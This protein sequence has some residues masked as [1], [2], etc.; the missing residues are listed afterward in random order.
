MFGVVQHMFWTPD[1]RMGRRFQNGYQELEEV[2]SW[3]F[4]MTTHRELERSETLLLVMYPLSFMW[5]MMII[6]QQFQQM[7]HIW[8]YLM[9]TYGHPYLR[10]DMNAHRALNMMMKEE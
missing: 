3:V 8:N 5:Y 2:N 1:F 9:G 6:S 7:D 10:E 4:L